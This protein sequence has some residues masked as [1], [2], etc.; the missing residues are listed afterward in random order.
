MLGIEQYK[1]IQKL[2]KIGL[3]K[4]KVSHQLNLSYK[5]ICNY[6]NVNE[7]VFSM[8]LKEHEF[9]LTNYRQYIIE[10]LKVC[11]QINNTVLLRTLKEDFPNLEVPVTSYHRYIKKVREET[12][13]VKPERK[14]KVREET[15]P[16][17]EGQV[18]FGQYVMK[19]MYGRNVRIYFFCMTL[20]Y[21][22][23]KFAYFSITPFTCKTTI[24]AHKYAFKYFGGRPQ[25]M[26]YD[27]DKTMVVSENLGDV[28][29]V[30][31]FEEYIRETGFSVYVCKGYDPA[32][33]GKIEKTVDFIK[34]QFLDGRVYYGLDQLNAEFLD[35]LDGEGNGIPNETT[36]K[37]PRE[38]FKNE[39]KKLTKVKPKRDDEVV[40]HTVFH[41]C[42]EYKDNL[43]KLPASKVNEGDRIRIESEGDT[44]VF[45]FALTNE[46]LCKH[47]MHPNV[48][49]IITLPEE[50]KEDASIEEVL[51]SIYKDSKVAKLF[52]KRMREQKPRYVYPQCRRISHMRKYYTDEQI[53][54][55]MRY[56]IE[57][58]ICSA[59]ELS[60]Y[61]LY[62]Y[63]ESI[64][65][66]YIPKHTY[67]T[68][69][70][71]SFAIKEEITNG[72]E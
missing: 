4:V 55:G 14:Y 66:K 33:K 50:V 40:I 57:K 48:G 5:T 60:S 44:L 49:H 62:K 54:E 18:D 3:S 34:R 45:Y 51:L 2:K 26:V 59:F 35:W 69:L 56:C 19:T 16:G 65:R 22:R 32:T 61:L 71:R 46:L 42:V 58:D 29:F 7:S 37:S 64:G 63:D 41:D 70:L 30:R 36:K 38:L 15:S 27:Q 52:I 13:L 17:Y 12:G 8:K 47:R 10:I 43:Y 28:I 11:P 68:Y 24:D 72:N 39:Y 31:D 23:M 21:S 9:V 6:W 67:N 53:I 1:K 20:S 25:M